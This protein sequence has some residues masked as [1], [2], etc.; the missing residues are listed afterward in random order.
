MGI[1]PALQQ[2]GYSEKFSLGLVTSSG[3]LGLL[4][5]PS[6]PLILYGIIAQQMNVGE[7]FTIQQLFI[8]GIHGD[9]FSDRQE[10][11]RAVQHIGFAV[12]RLL[13]QTAPDERVHR[14][15]TCTG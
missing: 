6:L 2:V 14:R 8:A 4:L 12:L 10:V 13:A 9:V 1:F 11:R 15:G 3:S 5:A 7:V